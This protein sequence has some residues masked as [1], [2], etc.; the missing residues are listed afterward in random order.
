MCQDSNEEEYLAAQSKIWSHFQASCLRRRTEAKT[1]KVPTRN[2]QKPCILTQKPLT[3]QTPHPSP[4]FSCTAFLWKVFC[5]FLQKISRYSEQMS[6]S[7]YIWI[8][9]R[10]QLEMKIL[11]A[12]FFIQKT[13]VKKSKAPLNR[14]TRIFGKVH[15]YNSPGSKE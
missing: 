4:T 10:L 14:G 8:W 2:K 13:I 11:L 6:P 15:L 9:Q 5:N 7:I 12:C 1:N 3:N